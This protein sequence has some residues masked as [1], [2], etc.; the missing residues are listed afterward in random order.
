VDPGR[1]LG[2][3]G[4]PGGQRET[5]IPQD[6]AGTARQVIRGSDERDPIAVPHQFSETRERLR[7]LSVLATVCRWRGSMTGGPIE[8]TIVLV[9]SAGLFVCSCHF[10]LAFF[11]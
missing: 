4:D 3:P 10:A 7:E 1:H 8:L 9:L 5:P 6:A 11:S 2:R